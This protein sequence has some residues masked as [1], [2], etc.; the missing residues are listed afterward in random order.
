[1]FSR[2]EPVAWKCRNCGYVHEGPEAPECCPACKHPQ[3]YYELWVEN[4]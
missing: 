4:Y 1:V 3:A 2:V